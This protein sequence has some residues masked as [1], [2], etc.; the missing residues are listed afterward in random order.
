MSFRRPRNPVSVPG[1]HYAADAIQRVWRAYWR[2]R[3]LQRL[4]DPS[5][6]LPRMSSDSGRPLAPPSMSSEE[7]EGR[8]ISTCTGQADTASLVA[9]AAVH[10]RAYDQRQAGMPD[11]ERTGLACIAQGLLAFSDQ[12]SQPV[13]QVPERQYQLIPHDLTAEISRNLVLQNKLLCTALRFTPQ[14]VDNASY[15]RPVAA[16]LR[17]THQMDLDTQALN[18]QQL[19]AI[20][21]YQKLLSQRARIRDAHFLSH[22]FSFSRSDKTEPMGSDGVTPL[23]SVLGRPVACVD[24]T[25][26]S[27]ESRGFNSTEIT[28]DWILV[29]RGCSDGPGWEKL[30]ELKENDLAAVDQALRAAKVVPM[31]V[32]SRLTATEIVDDI[33]QFEVVDVSGQFLRSPTP[34]PA[35]D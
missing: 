14:L 33:F 28:T 21:A 34:R 26:G 19:A 12:V 23:G 11:A 9:A 2:R 10:C 32:R 4:Q 1:L 3:F 27:E 20:Q 31:A 6:W 35:S 5:F 25:G 16:S 30:G 17:P 7:V 24:P 22:M 13:P 15:L 8:R 29:E 18:E